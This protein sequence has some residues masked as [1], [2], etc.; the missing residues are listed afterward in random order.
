M[1]IFDFRN[2]LVAD[3]AD[4]VTS[5]IAIRNARIQQRV[6]SELDEGFLWP[7]PSIGLNPAFAPGA[8][9]DEL[10]RDRILHEECAQIFR[11]K[12]DAHDV[13]SG[14]RL[15]RQSREKNVLDFSSYRS[16][17]CTQ[18][19]TNYACLRRDSVGMSHRPIGF[20]TPTSVTCAR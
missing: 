19:A 8:W 15:H 18:N 16:G 20:R 12:K 6:K 5:F 11:I 9:I 2:R 4:Y 7:E 10:V 13:G 17:D 3:Y 1:N 14:L